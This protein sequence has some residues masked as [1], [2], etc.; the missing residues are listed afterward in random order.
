VVLDFYGKHIAE[1]TD[2]LQGLL[3]K[4]RPADEPPRIQLLNEAD[5]QQGDSGQANGQAADNGEK[6]PKKRK[7]DAG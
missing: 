6:K 2:H 4:T 1:R 7:R 3:E 5:F